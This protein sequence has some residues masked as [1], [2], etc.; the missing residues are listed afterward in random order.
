MERAVA[1]QVLKD[2]KRICGDNGVF[3][4]SVDLISPS[5]NDGVTGYQLKIGTTLDDTCREGL[6]PLLKEKGLELEEANGFILIF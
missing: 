3:I 1:I 6:M 5:H 4:S 2:F